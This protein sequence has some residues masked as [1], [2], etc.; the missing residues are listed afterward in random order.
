MLLVQIRQVASFIAGNSCNEWMPEVW[1][2]RSFPAL[3]IRT[4]DYFLLH[5]LHARRR[6][7]A[8]FG[9]HPLG[10]LHCCV[11]SILVKV[12]VMRHWALHPWVLDTEV[13][14]IN[15]H[16]RLLCPLLDPTFSVFNWV[17]DPDI[18]TLFL[19]W[20]TIIVLTQVDHSVFILEVWQGHIPF[21]SLVR[22]NIYWLWVYKRAL[23]WKHWCRCIEAV[24]MPNYR[25]RLRFQPRQ[26]LI[27]DFLF[28]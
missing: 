11:R 16:S 28:T 20:L 22:H 8:R 5:D 7:H 2:S 4:V 6:S 3:F 24:M 10:V 17:H 26:L 9:L 15:V 14:I 27:S 19:D 25:V 12:S 1:Y 21:Y 13:Y 23:A 18:I